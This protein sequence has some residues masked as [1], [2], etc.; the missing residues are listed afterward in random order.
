MHSDVFNT[1]FGSGIT[2]V[3]NT[4]NFPFHLFILLYF[5]YRY[6]FGNLL[7]FLLS[8]LSSMLQLGA[9]SQGINL[10]IFLFEL[11]ANLI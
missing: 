7:L 5:F 4:Y 6:I 11:N 2:C 8:L 1:N 10:L 3:L 9:G